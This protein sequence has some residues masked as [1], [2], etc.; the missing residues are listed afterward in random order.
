[1]L[2]HETGAAPRFLALGDSALSIELGDARDRATSARVLAFDEAVSAAVAG[3]RLPG[4]IEAVPTFRT[5]TI[6]LD[7]VVTTPAEVADRVRGLIPMDGAAR[8]GGRRWRLPVCYE[9]DCAPDLAE[10]AARID[11]APADVVA[12]HSARTYDIYMLG[13][14]PGFGFMGDVEPVLDLPRRAEPRTRVPAGSVA[15]AIGLTAIYPFESPGGWHLLGRSPVLLFDLRRA[16]P[17]LF[18]PGD[19]VR[20][21]PVDRA[22]YDALAARAA[23]GDLGP[24]ALAEP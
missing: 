9:G 15:I 12:R 5:L 3:G 21:A 19:T 7:P 13:F 22:A 14:L 23:A 11:L 1:M 20:F 4:V 24:D 8:H 6:H 10:V 16:E 17:A 18:A 2:T